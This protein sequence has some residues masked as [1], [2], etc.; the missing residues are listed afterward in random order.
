MNTTEMS[1]NKLGEVLRE[2]ENDALREMEQFVAQRGDCIN[3]PRAANLAFAP[4]QATESE[5]THIAACEWCRRLLSK[6]RAAQHPA[7]ALLY[8]ARWRQLPSADESEV[9]AHMAT[10]R[11]CN[12]VSAVRGLFG[13]RWLEDVSVRFR[14]A[15]DN[16][17]VTP[18][19][20]GLHDTAGVARKLEHVA[21]ESAE[22]TVTVEQGKRDLRI[23]AYRRADGERHERAHVAL[24]G[25][26]DAIDIDVPLVSAGEW[27]AGGCQVTNRW[28][29]VV[30]PVEISVI[31]TES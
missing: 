14:T 7:I 13:T 9:M 26:D 3:V 10:C 1:S 22:W 27:W 24:V 2:I 20:V 11:R 4:S 5:R 28:A 6:W 25:P 15:L 31:V 19:A 8:A 21:F 18:G 23:A 17:F 12:T 30:D 16:S 29:S